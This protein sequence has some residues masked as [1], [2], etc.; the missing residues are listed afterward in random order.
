MYKKFTSHFLVILVLMGFVQTAVA[1]GTETFQNI[2][3]SSTSYALRN[4]TGVNGLPW[5][6]TDARTDQIING[7]AIAIK[8][9]SVTVA[10]IPNGVGNLSF[11]HQQIFT[12]SGSV[13]QVYI[14]NVL[15]G[16]ANPTTTL[17]TATFNNINVAGNFSL[18]IRQ[19]TS[20]LRIALDD[21]VWTAS[22]PACTP[23]ATQATAA[24]ITNITS[25]AFDI[26]FTPGNGTNSLVVV[27]A[28][29]A[30]SGN[31]VSGTPYTANSVFGTGGTISAGEFVVFNGTGNTV[32]VSG[33]STGTTY[34]I[35]VYTFNSSDNCYNTTVPATSSATTICIE[36][37]VQVNTIT[38]NPFTTSAAINWSGGNGNSSLVLFNTTNSFTTPADGTLYTGSSAYTS[39]QQVVFAGS[40]SSVTVTG[41][42]SN[43]TYYAT[44]FTYNNCGGTPDYLT[45]GN[46]VQSFT[47]T[48]AANY[49]SSITTQTCA[50]LK[51]ALSSII[52]NGVVLLPY[53][54]IDDV[55]HPTTDD[56]LNDAGTQTIVWDM[57]SDNPAGAE[58]Y[59]YTFAQAG[60][61]ASA[62]GQGWNKEHTFPNSWFSQTSST[63]NFPGSDLHQ[64]VPTDI[65][66][67]AQ[68]GNLPYG[69]VGTVTNTYTN[70]SKKGTSQTAIPNYTGEVFEPIDAYKGDLA[71][72]TLYMVTRYENEIPTWENYQATGDAVM[73]GLT[74]PSV[75]PAYL[76]MLLAWHAAD[77]VS[78]KE[79]E[80]NETVFNFQGNRNPFVDHPEYV[81]SIWGTSC[82]VVPVTLTSFTGI[83]NN[84][85]VLLYWAVNNEVNFKTYA[86]ERSFNGINFEKIG[87]VAGQNLSNYKFTDLTVSGKSVIY[88]RLKMIDIDGQFRYS[89][90]VVLKGNDNLPLAFIYPNPTAGELHIQLYESLLVKSTISITDLTGR[91]V[92]K[93][94]AEKG[95]LNMLLDIQNLPN[96]RYFIKIK[97]NYQLI[98]LS[99]VVIK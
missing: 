16:T 94:T 86:V 91:L 27:K 6:A 96:G 15:I 25:S 74:F 60:S 73:D 17:A 26:N 10:N 19:V 2:P 93:Q 20:G 33:L 67:N 57:Y 9:G 11:K 72:I 12:G 95:E 55:N 88:Y 75:E 41:L 77:P 42:I 56:H 50:P 70:G 65:Y 63:N 85:N 52:N 14:N 48:S 43:V 76:Q 32:T 45:T 92:K 51:T 69:I 89:S 82:L 4:W 54:S 35:S 61:S 21:V 8:N 99:F 62:E 90:V 39:G 59:T 24:A 30:V 83:R 47:T 98:D 23:P 68:R 37:T 97:N 34:H 18:E 22:G 53:G 36:P 81:Q 3:A 71:R 58:A 7:R 5:T 64:I 13:L 28:N 38:I 84:G 1:Q 79:T 49:Y 66:V 87:E 29:S 40:G 31:P 46:I 80:R 44:V 78:V